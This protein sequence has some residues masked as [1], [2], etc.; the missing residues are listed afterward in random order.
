MPRLRCVDGSCPLRPFTHSHT[1]HHHHHH[2]SYATKFG[3]GRSTGFACIYD[4]LEAAKKFEPKYRL[5]RVSRRSLPLPL[6]SCTFR[7]S[8]FSSRTC[9]F[10]AGTGLDVRGVAAAGHDSLCETGCL[11]DDEVLTFGLDPEFHFG[12]LQLP[13]GLCGSAGQPY[14]AAQRVVRCFV[15][16]L[17]AVSSYDA[18][19][20]YL[21]LFTLVLTSVVRAHHGA[22][23]RAGWAPHQ[24]IWV[25]QDEEGAQ[26]P[27]EEA[28]GQGPRR[29][30]EEEHISLPP[31][32]STDVNTNHAVP[33]LLVLVYH[34]RVRCCAQFQ[35]YRGS[36]EV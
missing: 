15:A 32:S 8:L 30:A 16:H 13:P 4:T 35:R 24:E 29:G 26:E 28:P 12:S 11:C 23:L 20:S 18:D 2:H 14:S 22:A 36:I 10:V 25:A 21:S 34:V 7:S 33:H 6:S 27:F 19:V 9:V 17:L 5:Q 3:G 31:F 1:H